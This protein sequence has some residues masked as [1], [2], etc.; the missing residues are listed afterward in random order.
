MPGPE[1]LTPMLVAELVGGIYEAALDPRLWR[2]LVHRIEAIYPELTIMM[3]SHEASGAA[4][5]LNVLVNY[6][7]AAL[8][9][10]AAYFFAHSPYVDF[11]PRN[12]VGRPVRTEVIIS[13]A[14][15]FRT[16]HYNDFMLPHGLGHYGTGMVLER[17]PEGWASLSFSDKAND[18]A[19][20]DHQMALLSLLA[21]HLQRAFKLRRTLAEAQSALLAPKT[22]FD[23][24][25]HAAFVLDRDGRVAVMNR[26]AEALVARGDGILLNR[27]GQPRSRDDRC[28]RALEGAIAACRAMA[29]APALA[30]A[31]LSGVMLPRTDGASALHAMLW[32]IACAAEFGLRTQPGQL[33]LIVS[34]PDDTPPG[35]ISWIA[36]RFGLSPA[37]E[38][39]TAEVVDG[40]PLADAAERL[41]IQLSTARTRLKTIQSKTGCHRQLDLVRLAMSVPSIRL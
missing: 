24:W 30:T 5:D 13:D 41:G 6:P 14:E 31:E 4:E 18:E 12:Q 23:S 36:R 29:D 3:F 16:E 35:A 2:D 25:G 37:E 40:V 20:R 33:L 9:D 28:S 10:Y 11:V 1:P 22:L 32:P 19:R 15:L 7:E 34:D 27:L 39:L 38:R 17:E 26:R 8:R 21:P